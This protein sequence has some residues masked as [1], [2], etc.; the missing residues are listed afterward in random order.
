M[1]KGA[2]LLIRPSG[3]VRNAPTHDAPGHRRAVPA[4]AYRRGA[5]R[6]TAPEPRH[7]PV[8]IVLGLHAIVAVLLLLGACTA[9]PA[10][11]ALLALRARGWMSENTIEL[12]RS[13]P[14]DRGLPQTARITARDGT[15]LAEID[16]VRYGRRTFVPL[17]E[18][19][20]DLVNATM[21]TED[22]RYYQHPG[23][24]PVGLVRAVGSN[25]E[26]GGVSQGGSTIEMQLT[27]NLFL[28]D[29]RTEQSLARKVKE[30][31][32]AVEL[33]RRYSKE[34]LL[35]A[36]LN[37]VFYG[38]RAFGAEA[39]AQVYFGKSARELT[40]PEASVLAGL[41]QSPS[42]YDP[43]LHLDAAKARQRAVLGRMVD[44]DLIT[45]DQAYEALTTPLAFKGATAPPPAR[46]QH[47]VNY[48]R[49]LARARF[50]PEVLFTGGL[51][52]RTTIDLETQQ[53][54]EQIVAQNEGIRQAAHANNTAMVVIEPATGQVLAMVGSKDF[55]DV[56]IA[57]QFN[58]ATSVRQPGSSIKPLVFLS[59]FEHGLSP[60]TL[61]MD[62]PTS[63]SAPPG[64]PA[65]RP[66]NY[67]HKYF[68]RLGLREALGNSLNVSSVKVLKYV[69]VP[70]FQDLARRLGI[71]TLDS[72]DPRWL[73]LTL[74][75]GEVRLLELTG[76]YA[77]VARGGNYVPI[78]SLLDVSTTRSEEL[79]LTHGGQRGRQ[80]VDPR[81]AYQ[82]LHVMGD[83]GARLLT[84]GAQT[85]L[86]LD[87]PHMVKTGTTDDYRDTWTIGCVPQVCVGVWM[88]NTNND[89]MVKVSSS[90]TAGRVW[91]EMIRTLVERKRWSPDP[92]PVPDGVVVKRIPSAGGRG[93]SSYEEVFIE[94]QEER[95]VLNLDWMR[96][97]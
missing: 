75:G 11:A 47:F 9:M 69:S 80:V 71:S 82:L 13:G 19:A 10:G 8:L 28:T 4:P 2:R 51:T 33:N 53:L 25:A 39:A 65:Y 21:A 3:K 40:L 6:K 63:F 72:W 92:W 41:P 34:D 76:A 95:T 60:A 59:A 78:E 18:M 85:P 54:A 48:V 93:E 52:I 27:R 26:A 12:P 32:A 50:G 81:A 66:E 17:K 64:Q 44:A 42:R 67:E 94:G 29:E 23:V 68:G 88:G 5:L 73:S 20:P 24:D 70:V 74:G 91:V 38:N 96:P 15:V 84:F 46:A 89:P 16:D 87:R 31:L 37:I 7:R 35:E 79:Y 58:V 56:S 22:R 43:L 45:A 86:N 1:S 49:E 97:D 57:G 36:Y 61:V 30:A 90:L 83:P 62:E 55:N 77:T 14:L